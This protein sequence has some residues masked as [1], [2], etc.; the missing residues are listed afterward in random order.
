MKIKKNK[1]RL[2]GE[3]R[4]QRP[5]RE[6]FLNFLSICFFLRFKEIGP[7]VFVRAEGKVGIRDESYA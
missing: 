7:L 5:E 3:R 2:H 1:S 6:R 4:T